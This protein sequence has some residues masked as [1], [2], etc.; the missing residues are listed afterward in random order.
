MSYKQSQ[1]H[2]TYIRAQNAVS[3]LTSAGITPGFTK[4]NPDQKVSISIETC[5][6]QNNLIIELLMQLHRKV[7]IL[8]AKG[9][10]QESRDK[11]E[12]QELTNTLAKLNLGG[13]ST[14]TSTA[15]PPKAV[16][17]IKYYVDPREILK[18]EQAKWAA[19][20]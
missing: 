4:A 10:L 3:E 7:E 15:V 17:E 1:D 18:E 2:S 20:K 5:I 16:R 12:L 8:S 11:K 6:Q 13:A 14:S 9:E 19:R